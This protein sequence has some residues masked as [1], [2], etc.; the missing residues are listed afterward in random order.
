MSPSNFWIR[1]WVLV[2]ALGIGFGYGEWEWVRPRWAAKQVWERRV[3]RA[4]KQ[5]QTLLSRFSET[6][7]LTEKLESYESDLA[8]L[9][10]KISA[11]NPDLL[12][13]G[14]LETLLRG[15]NALVFKG[16]E[17]SLG[18]FT[19]Q[20]FK[21]TFPAHYDESLRYLRLI[22]S[23][24]PSITLGSLRMAQKD[25]GVT[26]PPLLEIEWKTLY[27]SQEGPEASKNR[28]P[29][30]VS[31][32]LENLKMRDPF[33]FTR[34]ARPSERTP[35]PSFYVKE[36]I[37]RGPNRYAVI[38]GEVVGEGDSLSPDVL[39]KGI[40]PDRVIVSEKGNE[41]I[42]PVGSRS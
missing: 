27:R 19:E 34:E 35:G 3:E 32:D 2:M 20:K 4:D 22:E 9:R 37:F 17:T 30:P 13:H 40:S 23:Y 11:L 8:S 7:G 16:P 14:E 33:V 26:D 38:N 1:G 12:S 39:V 31:P 21:V 6:E 42:F 18:P 29:K 10:H 41:R 25:S 24:S 15:R 28:F 5:I 36:I